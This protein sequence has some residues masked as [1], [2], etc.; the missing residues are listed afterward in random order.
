MRHGRRNLGLV[1]L[2]APP[3]FVKN[4]T[5]IV[6][7]AQ[8]ISSGS[9]GIT[10]PEEVRTGV[11]YYEISISLHDCKCSWMSGCSRPPGSGIVRNVI[12]EEIA[13]GRH[14]QHVLAGQGHN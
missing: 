8:N 10:G 2:T 7:H 5:S 13:V 12:D 3:R 9:G 11:I 14:I 1:G 6:L 4:D